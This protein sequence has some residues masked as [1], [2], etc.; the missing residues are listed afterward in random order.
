MRESFSK[1]I[2]KENEMEISGREEEKK[3][4]GEGKERGGKE[5][6]KKNGWKEFV[7]KEREK[8]GRENEK[9][10]E[11]EERRG[12]ER[13]KENGENGTRDAP[14]SPDSFPSTKLGNNIT[15]IKG[16]QLGK[17]TTPTNR[18]PKKLYQNLQMDPR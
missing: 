12:R 2:G 5:E 7:R 9:V 17:N 8:G 4:E 6:K 14:P 13:K 1:K 11:G 15:P 16:R 18:S 3:N 10:G